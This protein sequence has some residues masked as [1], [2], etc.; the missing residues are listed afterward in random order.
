M[1]QSRIFTLPEGLV[2]AT[3]NYLGQ[4]PFSQVAP[5]MNALTQ[6]VREQ[7]SPEEL[8][9]MSG[10]QAAAAPKLVENA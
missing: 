1:S 10:Q 9:A 3:I 8:A 4:Q 7:L 5:L 6:A 2:V